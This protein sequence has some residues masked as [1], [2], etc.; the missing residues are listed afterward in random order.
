M[1]IPVH[2]AFNCHVVF[3]GNI[4]QV[5]TNKRIASDIKLLPVIAWGEGELA[6]LT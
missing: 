3:H 1:V 5:D 4:F 2:K 6:G